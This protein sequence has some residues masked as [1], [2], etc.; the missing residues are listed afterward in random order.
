MIRDLLDRRSHLVH[1]RWVWGGTLAAL[2]GLAV[3]GVGIALLSLP[4][5]TVGAAVLLLGGA[6]SAVGGV[7]YDAGSG[8]DPGKEL[9]Q[10]REGDAHEGTYPGEMIGDQR[11]RRDAAETS[12]QVRARVDAR[13]TARAPLAPG[14]GW[15]MLGMA[16]FVVLSQ[17]WFVDNTAVGRDTALR[18]TGLA[19]LL[20]LTGLGIASASRR[21]WVLL[22][23][24]AGAGAG[25]VL[26]GLLAEHA[27]ARTAGL[28]VACGVLTLAA[29]GM[30]AARPR[31][32]PAPR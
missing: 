5:S 20:G 9:E 2:V 7:M 26:A 4:L 28:E 25:F 15:A 19:V 24:A 10:V 13:P 8:A 11:A 12:R 16:G 3:L 23:L 18:D 32:A 17:P 22:V 14:A 31:S 6:A 1:P 29:V 21:H 30:A 27:N